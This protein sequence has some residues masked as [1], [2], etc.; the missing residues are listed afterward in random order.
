M[1]C[2]HGFIYI[3]R[4]K[5][6]FVIWLHLQWLNR[7]AQWDSGAGPELVFGRQNLKSREVH[8]S[9][10]LSHT[11]NSRLEGAGIKCSQKECVKKY[12]RSCHRELHCVCCGAQRVTGCQTTLHQVLVRRPPPQ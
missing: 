8:G 2:C 7:N 6:M 10:S 12:S 4:Y 1:E 3:I 11:R 9:L 5:I